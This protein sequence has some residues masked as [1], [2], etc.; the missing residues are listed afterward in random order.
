MNGDIIRKWS[1]AQVLARR[2]ERARRAYVLE[3]AKDVAFLNGVQTERK[4]NSQVQL[5]ALRALARCD[6]LEA[7]LAE[8]R[9]RRDAWKAKA[10][11]Y[12]RIRAALR[13]KVGAPW[14]PSLSRSLWA[15]LAADQKKRA[16]DAEAENARLREALVRIEDLTQHNMGM[17][18]AEET[19]V[20]R[21]ASAALKGVSDDH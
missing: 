7:E 17:N 2:A 20:N 9:R 21:E 3:C 13:K 16:D 8:A 18:A 1:R 12:D 5:G 11:D 10:E 15:A 19:Y 4:Y 14:P 6:A